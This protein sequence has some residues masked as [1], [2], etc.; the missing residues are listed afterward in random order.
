MKTKN[1]I[2]DD[3]GSEIQS[4]FHNQILKDCV[5][6]VD[7]SRKK[8]GTYYAQWDHNIEVFESFMLA[9][10]EDKEAKERKEPSKSIV[11]IGYSQVMTFIAFCYTLFTQRERMFELL[12]MSTEDHESAKI[13]EAFIQRDLSHNIFEQKLFQFLLDIS[14]CSIGVFK[15][16]WLRETQMIRVKSQQPMMSFLGLNIGSVETETTQEVTKYLGNKIDNVS[17]YRFFPDTRLPLSRFQEGEFCASEDEFSIVSLKQLEPDGVVFGIDFIKSQTENQWRDRGPSRTSEDFTHIS[18]QSTTGAGGQTKGT[19]I[20]T[21][22]Q[23]VLIPSKYMID[24]KPM[25]T[26]DYPV[27]YLIWYANDNRVI[28]CEPL[29]Y[30]HNEFTYSLSQ[31]NPDQH[32][33]VNMS[34][35]DSIDALQ[36]II[37]WFINS[38]ITSVR[39]VIQ[40][41]LVV[42]PNGVEMGDIKERRSVIRLKA[43][44]AGGIDRFVKQLNVT[45][46]TQNHLA[47]VSV[48][49]TLIQVVTGISD[50]MLG[51]FHQGRRSAR[52]AGQVFSGSANRLKMHATIIFRT[53]LETMARQML[54]NLR[55]GLDEEAMVRLVGIDRTT[56]AG[57]GFTKADKSDLVGNYDFEVFDGTLPSEKQLNAQTLQEILVGLMSNP[58]SAIALGLDPRAILLEMLELKGIR[59]PERF[60]L[61]APAL[62]Q[63]QN[64]NALQQ[65][66]SGGPALGPQNPSGQP[67]LSILP[68]GDQNQ[69]GQSP[70]AGIAGGSIPAGQ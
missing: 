24:G 29:N 54:S 21:E 16:S 39:K 20:V 2:Q 66:Q 53:G 57:Q 25:G 30:L 18:R 33:L 52:E 55:D 67:L 26:E 44:A 13:G 27:K 51:Q 63:Q 1:P 19:V 42:D 43:T 61:Q 56:Q 35:S 65:T 6:L 14:R 59:N 49:Q 5:K 23:R 31:F 68:G 3:L 37:T 7:M 58:E 69:G 70:V 22:V 10:K 15:I 45:D 12:G 48:L 32:S 4:T 64:P 34:L 28:R 36:S 8:M 38:H 41:Y 47:D 46:V 50:N 60:S 62:Q 40:N 9:D 17:P 11:P